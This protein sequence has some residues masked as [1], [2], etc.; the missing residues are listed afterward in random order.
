M[1]TKIVQAIIQ[2][3]HQVGGTKAAVNVERLG[4]YELATEFSAWS[5]R[6]VRAKLTFE[7]SLVNGHSYPVCRR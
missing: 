2:G 6:T 4:G 3:A 5:M 1:W 7:Q